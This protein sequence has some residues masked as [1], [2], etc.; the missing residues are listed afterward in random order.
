MAVNVLISSQLQAVFTK[1]MKRNHVQLYAFI[2]TDKLRAQS[3]QFFVTYLM[4]NLL[5]M[6]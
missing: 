3:L 6:C 1:S 4:F 5:I 2:L